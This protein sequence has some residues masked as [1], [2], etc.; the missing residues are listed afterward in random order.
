[1]R[2]IV[3]LILVL[4]CSHAVLPVLHLLLMNFYLLREFRPLSIEQHSPA[5]AV[6][7]HA[8]QHK[9]QV[10][11]LPRVNI[12]GDHSTMDQLV[13]RE[14]YAS[15][16]TTVTRE[17]NTSVAYSYFDLNGCP[18]LECICMEIRFSHLVETLVLQLVSAMSEGAL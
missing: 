9:K 3:G 16:Y 12:E 15:H 5:H 18:P 13:S 8:K 1:M 17:T 14:R 6:L 11:G 2:I 10:H 4:C 7:P